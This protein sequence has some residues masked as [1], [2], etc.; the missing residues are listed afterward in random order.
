MA[1]L[2]AALGAA[3]LMGSSA[4]LSA[5]HLQGDLP[6]LTAGLLYTGYLIAV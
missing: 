6:A 4:E 1:L 2:L 5:R 3:L